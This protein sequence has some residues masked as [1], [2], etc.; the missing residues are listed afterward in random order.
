MM[1]TLSEII[2][3]VEVTADKQTD[4]PKTI[5]SHCIYDFDGTETLPLTDVIAN[6]GG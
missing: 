4:T 6:Q 2:T 3:K 5:R 1:S